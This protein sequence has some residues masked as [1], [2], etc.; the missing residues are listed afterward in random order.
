VIRGPWFVTPHAVRRYTRRYAR[1][2]DYEAARDQLVDLCARA[3]YVR[4]SH[5]GELW[6]GPRPLRLRLV[7][8]RGEGERRA[9]VTV[10]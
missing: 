10:L 6:R 1:R 4:P 3:R 2:L 8:G 7:V 9:L 5:G